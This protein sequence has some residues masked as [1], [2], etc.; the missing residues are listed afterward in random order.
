MQTA[1][2]EG[3]APG[4]LSAV[5]HGGSGA[6]GVTTGEM[7]R[8][9]TASPSQE[10]GGGKGSP[11]VAAHDADPTQGFTV[12]SLR[13]LVAEMRQ[14]GWAPVPVRG[15]D[16]WGHGGPLGARS[17]TVIPRMRHLRSDA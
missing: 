11:G 3:L 12:K 13:K 8:M 15:W 2:A 5:G 16:G 17:V 4:V 6:G 9:M 1:Q 10:P 7:R 14:K